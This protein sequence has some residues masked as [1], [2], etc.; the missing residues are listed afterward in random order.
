MSE[1][2][3]HNRFSE[4]IT[5]HQSALYGYIFAVVRNR[6]DAD[7][8]FQSLCVVLW[9]KF[10][11]FQPGTSFFSWARRSARLEISNFLRR[12]QLPSYVT[13]QVLDALTTAVTDTESKNEEPYLAALRRCQEKLSTTDEELLDLRYTEE[14][15]VSEIA[16][17][18]H[19]LQ[20]SV[21]RS[22]SRIRRWLLECVQIE[23]AQQDQFGRNTHE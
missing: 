5:C 11:S 10:D 6:Q 15:G 17:R 1:Q 19:R 7:D 3:P 21:S 4:L 12:K 22:L 16:D 20:P 9:R 2:E 13:E 14:L 8:L 23:L 18:L